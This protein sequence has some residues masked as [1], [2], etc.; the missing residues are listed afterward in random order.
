MRIEVQVAGRSGSDRSPGWVEVEE[1][2]LGR[3][4]A[5]AGRIV[6][7]GLVIGL[8]FL[9]IPLIHLFGVMVFLASLVLALHR[10]RTRRAVR[11]AGGHCPGCGQEATFFVG[12]GTS[13]F[14]LPISTSCRHCAMALTLIQC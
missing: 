4:V 5:R 6:L 12:L 11:G 2:S 1:L 9:P 13:R 3:R 8:V 10:F 7:I 14:R